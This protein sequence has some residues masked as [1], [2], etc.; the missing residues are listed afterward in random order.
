MEYRIIVG[1]S[2]ASGIILAYKTIV[3]LVEAGYAVE[4]VI[5]SAAL[6][7]AAHELGREYA[8][9]KRFV[10]M[11][12]NP[13]VHKVRLHSIH[14]I[15]AAIASGS[16]PVEGMVIVPCSMATL[17]AVAY[18]FA[19]NCLRRAADVTLKE[20]RPLILV[21]REAPLS[22][23]HL[24]NMLKVAQAGG[25]ILPPVPA[26][27]NRPES[28][29]DIEGWIVAKILDQLGIKT[30][31]LPQWKSTNIPKSVEE[32]RLGLCQ[33]LGLE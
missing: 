32:S 15:G 17:A 33:S 8:T 28:L 13:C 21:P 31:Q 16:Y 30:A 23:I 5:S 24:E 25:V 22:I 29:E 19:D 6:Y 2:G 18:G 20:K 14:D 10:Q 11:L 9:A 27:Y 26:W 12:P 7:T 3:A 4:L 1:I